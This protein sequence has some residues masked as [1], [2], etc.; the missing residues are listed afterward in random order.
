[1]SKEEFEKIHIKLEKIDTHLSRLDTTLVA[2]A[3]DVEYHIKRTDKIEEV[4][5]PE[6]TW[7]VSF[8]NNI[9]ML[10]LLALLAATLLSIFKLLDFIGFIS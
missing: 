3:K 4:L 5:L 7:A 1:M 9:K 10:S 8:K 6:H 2:V